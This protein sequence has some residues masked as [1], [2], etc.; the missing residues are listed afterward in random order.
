MY[1]DFSYYILLCQ[2][3]HNTIGKLFELHI[4][5]LLESMNY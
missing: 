3:P 2:I 1:T 4:I 5:T